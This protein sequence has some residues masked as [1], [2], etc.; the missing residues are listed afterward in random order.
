[1]MG[2]RVNSLATLYTRHP[3]MPSLVHMLDFERIGEV[4]GR[5]LCPCF[6]QVDADA[7]AWL[8]SLHDPAQAP[9]IYACA[10]MR[11]DLRIRHHHQHSAC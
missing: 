5:S 10:R 3:I 7:M 2:I 6:P 9:Y 1:M 8:H 11:A 4:A